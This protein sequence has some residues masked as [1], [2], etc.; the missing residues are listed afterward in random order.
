VTQVFE[1]SEQDNHAAFSFG[2]ALYDVD[3]TLEAG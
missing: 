2:V 3:R 1:L